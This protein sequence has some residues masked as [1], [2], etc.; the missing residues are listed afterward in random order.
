MI[1]DLSDS[2]SHF[3]H[4]RVKVFHNIIMP[5]QKESFACTCIWKCQAAVYTAFHVFVRFVIATSHLPDTV[6]V[7]E[8]I[9]HRAC[10]TI[11]ELILPRSVGWQV[12]D[13]RANLAI[14]EIYL[15]RSCAV[16]NSLEYF[17][18]CIS[19]WNMQSVKFQ[20]KCRQLNDLA[21]FRQWL[22]LNQYH[23]LWIDDI[24]SGF[25][26]WPI[27]QAVCSIWHSVM[28]NE[29]NDYIVQWFEL[30]NQIWRW[31]P[32]SYYHLLW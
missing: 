5:F 29:S 13:F 27:H 18:F 11:D 8:G 24:P 19:N 3:K 23:A 9:R 32:F 20:Q 25:L 17:G 14:I 21:C 10:A 4:C 12:H 26:A 31:S 7:N 15:G 16:T 1:C 30:Q 6:I 28:M 22:V 2:W